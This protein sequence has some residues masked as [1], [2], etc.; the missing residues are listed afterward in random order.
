MKTS[1]KI[2]KI[3]SINLVDDT[4]E[5]MV[6]SQFGKIIRIDTKSVRSAGRSTSGVRL[7]NLDTDDKVASATVI[8]PEN[9]KL[10]GPDGT[11]L[12]LPPPSKGH[13]FSRAI[14]PPVNN[15]CAGYSSRTYCVDLFQMLSFP[16]WPNI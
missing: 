8:P 10:P 9:P 12:R 5:M 11:L 1:S 14:K 15:K 6:I 2:G 13:G 4:I 7:L 3:T 16:A